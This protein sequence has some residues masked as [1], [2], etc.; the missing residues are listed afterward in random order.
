MNIS[1]KSKS[2]INDNLEYSEDENKEIKSGTDSINNEELEKENSTKENA[3]I[4]KT[5]VEEKAEE[6]VPGSK[7]KK[8]KKSKINEEL[9]KSQVQE[10]ISKMEGAIQND[11]KNI[12]LKKPGKLNSS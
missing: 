11:K 2:G 1:E 9:I 6:V 7:S 10:M 8:K 4:E 5:T 12:S 3:V